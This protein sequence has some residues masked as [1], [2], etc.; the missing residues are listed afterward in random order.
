[1]YK[2]TLDNHKHLLYNSQKIKGAPYRCPYYTK[3]GSHSRHRTGIFYL[4]L[5]TVPPSNT[6]SKVK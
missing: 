3:I 2:N 1:M 6:N 4:I 5:I